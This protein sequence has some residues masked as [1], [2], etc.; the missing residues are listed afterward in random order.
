M[1][2][3]GEH[4]PLRVEQIISHED[5]ELVGS[6]PVR[7]E[8]VEDPLV[9]HIRLSHTGAIIIYSDCKDN[10]NSGTFRSKK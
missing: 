5:M 8:A 9:P 7:A 10:P 1:R 2:I 3:A 6:R 4:T